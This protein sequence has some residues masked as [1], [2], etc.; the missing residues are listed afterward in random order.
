[1]LVFDRILATCWLVWCRHQKECP[2]GLLMLVKVRLGQPYLN[3]LCWYFLRKL[4]LFLIINSW[5]WN[6]ISTSKLKKTKW[7]HDICEYR[8]HENF[9]WKCH[10]PAKSLSYI[11]PFFINCYKVPNFFYVAVENRTIKLGLN[12]NWW[13]TL[14]IRQHIEKMVQDN[15]IPRP[16][17]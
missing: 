10:L 3:I 7:N 11:A 5:I 1:M 14:D 17:P 6:Q 15:Q 2:K 13:G 8:L 16:F 4:Q 9:C 12:K